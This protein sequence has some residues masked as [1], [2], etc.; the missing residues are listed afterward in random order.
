MPDGVILPPF[1]LVIRIAITCSDIE[2]DDIAT[3]LRVIQ[4]V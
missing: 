3:A 4:P 2:I 1:D